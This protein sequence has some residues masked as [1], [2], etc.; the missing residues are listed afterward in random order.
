MAWLWKYHKWLRWTVCSLCLSWPCNFKYPYVVGR[1]STFDIDYEVDL[2]TYHTSVGCHVSDSLT[3]WVSAASQPRLFANSTDAHARYFVC[4]FVY[5]SVSPVLNK[6]ISKEKDWLF[7]LLIYFTYLF[8]L[9]LSHRC[10]HVRERR[11]R[12]R[13]VWVLVLVLRFGAPYSLAV[14]SRFRSVWSWTRSNHVIT[15]PVW[16]AMLIVRY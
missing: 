14:H 3:L 4:V 13:F 12:E 16:N 1:N 8:C 9:R 7:Y 2:S 5:S 10:S 11:S 6:Q 15:C